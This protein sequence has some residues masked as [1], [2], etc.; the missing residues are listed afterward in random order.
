M[1]NQSKYISYLKNLLIVI[2]LSSSYVVK[3]QENRFATYGVEQGLPQAY[4]YTISQNSE[5][6]LWFGTGNGLSKFNGVDF[7]NYNSSDSLGGDFV[8]ST[9][10]TSKGE[11][12]GHNNGNLSFKNKDGFTKIIPEL[13]SKSGVSDLEEDKDGNVWFSNQ[14]NGLLKLNSDNEVIPIKT[15]EESFPIFAFEFL[16]DKE[17]LVGSVNG[18]KHCK[19]TNSD[20]LIIISDISEIAQNRVKNIV[21]SRNNKGFYILSSNEEIHY[22]SVTKNGFVVS[23]ISKNL[24]FSIGSV[25]HLFEDSHSNLWISTFGEGLHK[26]EKTE[27]GYQLINTYNESNGLLTDNVKLVFEDNEANI[28]VSL[29]GKGMVRLIDPSFT[30]YSPDEEKYGITVSAICV[31]DQYE[32]LGMEK[33]LLRRSKTGDRSSKFYDSYRGLPF[34]KITALYNRT[35]N[36]LWVGTAK[37]GVYRLNVSEDK[38][39]RQNIGSGILENSINSITGIDEEIWI[40]TKKGAYHLNL[41]TNISDWYTISKGGIPHNC[42]NHML[43]DSQDRVWVSTLSSSIAYISDKTVTKFDLSDKKAFLD[44]RSITE[45][46]DGN[47]WV[48]TKGNGVF[49]INNDSITNLTTNNGLVSDY[50]Y[51]LTSD[52]LNRMWI[53]HRGGISR[54]DRND[55]SIKPLKSNIGIN[56]SAEFQINSSFTDSENKLW[57]GM[58]QGILRFDPLLEQHSN[59]APT[60][61]INSV[62][63]NDEEISFNKR[64][65]LSPGRYKITIKYIGINF[66]E[67]NLV[68]Y[69]HIYEGYDDTWTNFSPENEITYHGVS[70]GNFN[71]ILEA[72]SGDGIITPQAVS[73]KFYVKTPFWKQAWFY[74]LIFVLS[75]ISIIVYI[76][77]REQKL[78]KENRVLEEKVNQRTVEIVKQKEEIEKQRDL[79]KSKNKDITDSIKYASKIQAAV[80]PPVKYLEE[81]LTDSFIINKPK[82]IVSGDFY[83]LTQI[84]NKTIIAMADC[85]GHGVPGAFMSMLGVTFLNEIVNHKKI[86]DPKEVL[87]V[88]RKNIIVSLRQSDEEATPSDGMDISLVVIDNENNELTF[89]GAFNPVLIVRDSKIITLK[90]DRMPIGIYHRKN[91]DFSSHKMSITPGDMIYLYTDGYPDQ[92]GGEQDRKFTTRKFKNILLDINQKPMMVQKTILENT[93]ENWMNGTE[94]ID[95]ITVLGVRIN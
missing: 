68:K 16:A 71:F 75:I 27:N 67:P 55:L 26:I 72:M 30:F 41:K 36:D 48:G 37:H 35:P 52:S 9:L 29:Y 76:K 6:F 79:I 15:S 45:D 57:F 78:K 3:S 40:A 50:C 64:I 66:K 13:E 65:V 94:Q 47:I 31:D 89:S 60:L 42:V 23:D 18:L 24:S 38:F 77:Q 87:N 63:I 56:K 12:Y 25:Q 20:E 51:S 34:D 59:L 14:S 32:W 10:I 84:E 62:H 5:G 95:D 93:M 58:N 4:V 86:I 92:F 91:M 21:K 46:L 17:L 69:R 2:Y 81:V 73:I 44:I 80:V 19:L 90:A 28:W 70:D 74:I 82:D 85:T 39:V 61:K 1:S 83:W 88:L 54:V 7:I 53:T 33:G 22:L 8:T 49:L 43:V 11:W